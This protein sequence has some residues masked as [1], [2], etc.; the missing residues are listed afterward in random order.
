[1]LSFNHDMVFVKRLKRQDLTFDGILFEICV[2][3]WFDFT[4]VF[5]KNFKE[6]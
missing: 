2:M 3:L 6:F 4:W 1:M 5:Q